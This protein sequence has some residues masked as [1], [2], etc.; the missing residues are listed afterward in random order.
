MKDIGAIIKSRS[1]VK[2][3]LEG[4]AETSDNLGDGVNSLT[5]TLDRA[6]GKSLG[7]K[8]MKN[9]ATGKGAA[10]KSVD[11]GGQ[12]DQL[13]TLKDGMVILKINGNNVTECSGMKEIGAMIKANDKATFVL[14]NDAS[15]VQQ[16]DTNG[17]GQVSQAELDA[18]A[19][20][21]VCY[22][23]DLGG[24]RVSHIELLLW[25]VCPLCS[26]TQLKSN[27]A[28]C[29]RC[30]LCP[31]NLRLE[32]CFAPSTWR[33]ASSVHVLSWVYARVRVRV[34]WRVSTCLGCC[35]SSLHRLLTR[36]KGA[37][38]ACAHFCCWIPSRGTFLLRTTLT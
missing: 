28:N 26:Q 20:K 37:W 22:C 12:A 33:G 8:L 1:D 11:V 25:C 31:I 4:G 7:I 2:F 10:I 9:P 29:L 38:H 23:W 13:G 17:D 16:L 32:M 35:Q 27:L 3:T 36:R 34:W 30:C 6:N 19:K 21:P 15:I 5:V 14:E 24:A 18:Y